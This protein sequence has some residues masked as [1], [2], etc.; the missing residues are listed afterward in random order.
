MNL[1]SGTAMTAGKH[2]SHDFRM[3]FTSGQILGIIPVDYSTLSAWELDL[4][5]VHTNVR[6]GDTFPSGVVRKNLEHLL[7]KVQVKVSPVIKGKGNNLS[8]GL[9]TSKKLI[10]KGEVIGIYS[11]IATCSEGND[12]LYLF[13]LDQSCRGGSGRLGISSRVIDGSPSTL[14]PWTV[15]GRINEWVW[16]SRDEG[17]MNNCE[18]LPGGIIVAS[19]NL[20]D[21]E[22]FISYGSD[23]PWYHVKIPLLRGIPFTLRKILEVC[24]ASRFDED[25]HRL[26]G[27]IS[28]PVLIPFEIYYSQR[29]ILGG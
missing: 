10:T 20:R 24:N 22:I 15:F 8:L 7:D 6:E 27:V 23:Y 21:E 17:L 5:L 1:A 26:E 13:Q 2:F 3:P 29:L 19:R 28:D 25:I 12:S 18:V 14:D 11:G 16:K 4:C 9:F